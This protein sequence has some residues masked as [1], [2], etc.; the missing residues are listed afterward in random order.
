[1]VYYYLVS[2]YLALLFLV[3]S[4]A[5][6]PIACL[7][8]LAYPLDRKLRALHMFSCFWGSCYTWLNPI[9]G[10][11][12]TGRENIDRKKAY[13]MISNHQSILDILVIYRIFV[14]FKWVAKASLFKLPVIG[15]NM[16][17]NRYIRIER[18]SMK[19]QRKMIRECMENIRNGNSV[20]I[21]PEGTRSGNGR[22]RSFKDGA[23]LIA[24]YQKADIVP[25]VLDGTFGAVPENKIIPR[26]KRRF[27]L[28]IMKPVPYD[29]FKDMTAHEASTYISRMM[30]EELVNI[31]ASSGLPAHR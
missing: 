30:E 25:M 17:L 28:H 11:T 15:W 1:M 29:D 20:M 19:S 8:A 21:F 31:R 9:W 18:S 22:L 27:Y 12:I 23:F 14:H 10:V 2:I 4:I 6:L 3:T 26:S 7:L 5:F 16:K 13:V 24:L